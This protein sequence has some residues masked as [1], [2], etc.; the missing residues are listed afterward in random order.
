MHKSKY[1]DK[2]G[3]MMFVLC[4][5]FLIHYNRY[6]PSQSQSKVLHQNTL[7]R[8]VLVLLRKLNHYFKVEVLI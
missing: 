6:H 3:E 4:I 2:A 5:S 7:Q 8:T 1:F